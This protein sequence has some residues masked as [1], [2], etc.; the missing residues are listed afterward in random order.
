MTADWLCGLGPYQAELGACP[1]SD[2][3]N[4]L[5]PRGTLWAAGK[6]P[7][8][9]ALGQALPAVLLPAQDW[10]WTALTVCT[11]PCG[12]GSWL[13]STIS[14]R[15][16]GDPPAAELPCQSVPSCGDKVHPGGRDRRE[17]GALQ[18]PFTHSLGS[19][20][21][22]HCCPPLPTDPPSECKQERGLGG[23]VPSRSPT[24]HPG[25]ALCHLP[26]SQ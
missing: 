17:P 23:H 19:R 6:E 18:G 4:C 11:W 16:P 25:A 26:P 9:H 22:G 7:G 10:A 13:R 1:G 8:G 14:T 20:S 15:R 3:G 24:S 5:G 12:L 21:P 2:S